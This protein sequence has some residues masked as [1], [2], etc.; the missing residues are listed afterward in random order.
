MFLPIDAICSYICAVPFGRT[1]SERV[2]LLPD[3]HG[4]VCNK[5]VS[6]S[7]QPGSCGWEPSS[8]CTHVP[9]ASNI[10]ESGQVGCISQWYL[11][12]VFA[13]GLLCWY[14]R[15]L[16]V[17]PVLV[18][19]CKQRMHGNTWTNPG[20]MCLVTVRMAIKTLPMTLH[21][22]ISRSPRGSLM[23]HTG[24]LRRKCWTILAQSEMSQRRF[25]FGLQN[26]GTK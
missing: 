25:R 23:K 20:M 7:R 11:L 21:E 6:A 17:Y 4:L 15:M 2:I 13:P 14:T 19:I 10:A 1:H 8:I 9:C 16:N 26:H 5:C 12:V 24:D 3:Y 22:L 18:L